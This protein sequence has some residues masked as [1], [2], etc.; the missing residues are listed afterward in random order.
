MKIAGIDYS[1]CSPAI[2]ILDTSS[3]SCEGYYLTDIKRNVKDCDF[4]WLKVKGQAHNQYLAEE[5]RYDHIS[6]WALDTVEDCDLVVMED[7]ALGAKG[8]VFHIGENAGL[9][10]WKMWRDKISFKLVGPTTLKK[11]AT[12]KG[13]ADKHQV[14]EA[15]VETTGLNLVLEMCPG[16]TKVANP[17]SDLVDSY[18]LAKYGT[19]KEMPPVYG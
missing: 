7:Y 4:G 9:L 18:W 15:F 10:K 19:Q 13:N 11:F 2:T 5:Q 6:Q 12:G 14:H 16:S 3:G 1:I 8:K 17:V